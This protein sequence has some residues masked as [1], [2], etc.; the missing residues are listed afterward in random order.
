[1]EC[2]CDIDFNCGNHGEEALYWAEVIG[3][4]PYPY[5]PADAYDDGDYKLKNWER[6][7]A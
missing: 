3:L 1:M 7:V 6:W 2:Q 4:K 5:N